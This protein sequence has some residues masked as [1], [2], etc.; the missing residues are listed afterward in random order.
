[1]LNQLST[2]KNSGHTME[3]VISQLILLFC[4]SSHFC[5]PKTGKAHPSHPAKQKSSKGVYDPSI[6]S[7]PATYHL[8]HA[9][10]RNQASHAMQNYSFHKIRNPRH[11]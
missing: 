9:H 7:I 5:H 6:P 11:L 1:M 8:N 4:V 10:A 2:I 3:W